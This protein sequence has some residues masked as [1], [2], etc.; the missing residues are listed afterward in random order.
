MANIVN[1]IM[2]IQS[3]RKILRDNEIPILRSIWL[4]RKYFGLGRFVSYYLVQICAYG[5]RVGSFTLH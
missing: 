4:E 1:I 5:F 3:V 2:I